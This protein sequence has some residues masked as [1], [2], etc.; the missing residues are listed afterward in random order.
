[1]AQAQE[2]K[3]SV[4]PGRVK[5]AESARNHWVVTVEHGTGRE[6]LKRPEFWSLVGKTFKPYDR[7]EVRADDGTFFAE[8]VVCSADRAWAK[9]HELRFEILGTQDVSLTQ[10]AAA[11]MRARYSIK[12]NGPHLRY[13]VE[14]KDGSKTERLKEKCQDQ[15]EASAW[16]EG[17]LKTV[18]AVAVPA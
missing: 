7:I 4:M 14:R 3:R 1:M 8:Y 9:V 11:D 18:G 17:H 16:L 12:Y 15:A 13:C 2:T 6:D 10:A 5:L